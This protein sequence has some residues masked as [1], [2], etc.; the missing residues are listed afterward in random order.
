MSPP[1]NP[2]EVRHFLGMANQ[3]SK[4]LP[5]LADSTKPLR[6]LL[7]KHHE[8]DVPQKQAFGAIQ[9]ALTSPPV[10][11]LYD[12]N[13]PT[14]V[15]A[16][17]SS[18]GLGAVLMQQQTD[19]SSQTV[20]FIS[21]A[22][23]K[24]EQMYA[25]IEKEALAITWACDRFHLYL[26]GLRFHIE[27]DH[28]PLAPLLSSKNLDDLPVLVQRFQLRL[29]RYDFSISHVPGK[30]LI[31]ADA[32]SR[33]PDKISKP[34]VTDLQHSE[35][36]EY[37]NHIIS[38]LP[39][40]EERLEQIWRKQ[41]QDNVCQRLTQYCQQGWPSRELSIKGGLLMR[42][43][44]IVI[45]MVL[46]KEILDRL[47]MGL[48]GITKCR[49]RARQSVWWLHISTQIEGMVRRCSTCCMEQKPRAE[50]MIP[51]L[52]PEGPW[53]KVGMD[54]FYWDQATYLLI[55]DYYSHFIEVSRL[56][57]E[58]V[59]EVIRHTKSIFAHHGIPVEVISDNGPQFTSED[60]RQFSKQYCF[61]HKTSSPYHPQ[62]N[63]E[64]ERAVQTVYQRERMS[65]V[66]VTLFL[67][68]LVMALLQSMQS[69]LIT[70]LMN[71][72]V[73]THPRMAASVHYLGGVSG[74]TS[75]GYFMN[76]L[77]NDEQRE[78]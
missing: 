42:G 47:H 46:Q 40:T 63:E 9:A 65:T 71:L 50:P 16:D 31:I 53:H 67:T 55:I 19:G 3:L 76:Q 37:V 14:T 49:Q 22:M 44:R 8:W 75:Q 43:M 56:S 72:L 27:T 29:M 54:L 24:T 7:I 78:M 60:L 20:A 61:S 23:T 58:S 18:F 12:P 4:F 5:D 64:A 1:S 74:F 34:Y 28:K 11:T 41:Q 73:Q 77:G 6:D 48:Q 17:A 26:Y 59:N 51:S 57:N 69:Q 35:V 15:S 70:L 30:D 66:T 13:N 62:G 45:P 21:R 39:A 68:T 33:A 32:L 25:Q 10:L 36:E 52:F 38:S 2:S